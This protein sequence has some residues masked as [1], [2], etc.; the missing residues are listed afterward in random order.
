MAI[1][2]KVRHCQT[3]TVSHSYMQARQPYTQNFNFFLLRR[4]LQPVATGN[5]QC[6]IV[7]DA[8]KDYVGKK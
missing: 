6:L 2:R 3:A 1:E 8:F 4:E 7:S 5:K